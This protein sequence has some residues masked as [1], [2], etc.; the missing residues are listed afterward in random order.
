M[1][2]APAARSLPAPFRLSV[3]TEKSDMGEGGGGHCYCILHAL[4]G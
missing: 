4:V 1:V 2:S 3:S